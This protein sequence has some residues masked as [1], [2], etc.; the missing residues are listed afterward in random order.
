M[1]VSK[2]SHAR[3]VALIV[4]TCGI[5]ITLIACA[6]AT[7]VPP[8]SAPPPTAAPAT[9]APPPPATQAP[10]VNL[11]I[12]WW[13]EAD[14][15]GLEKWLE[16]TTAMYMKEN[17]NV[18][19]ETVL[20]S[21]ESLYPAFRAAAQAK[22]GPDVQYLWGAIYTLEDAW[23][24]N[25]APV[26]DYAQ[27]DVS[28]IFPSLREEATFDGKV[29]GLGWYMVPIT[30]A[31]RKDLFTQAGLDPN[32]PPATWDELL[33]A[34]EKL[35]AIGV[36]PLGYGFK[37]A[38]GHGNFAEQ[39][40]PQ[41]LDQPWEMLKFATGEE[42]FA[43]P[44]YVSWLTKVD[45]LNKKGC[46]N[47]DIMS[48][49]YQQGMDQLPAGKAAM[50]IAPVS[51]ISN[52]EKDLGA[53]KVGVMLAPVFGKGKIAGLMGNTAQV[54]AIPSFAPNKEASAAYL[55]YL[56]RPDRLK[57]MY[58]TSRALPADDR[59]DTSAVQSP[60]DKQVLAWA[61]D[62]AS[63]SYQDYIPSKID[64]ES[65]FVSIDK[66]ILGEKTPEQAAQEVEDFA[67]RWR[68]DNPEQLATLKKWLE[69]IQ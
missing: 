1:Q 26:S 11:T 68:T 31:Y 42:S 45:E 12:W 56:H 21:T 2:V 16:E 58:E 49:D 22:K 52:W 18:K 34:C 29:W 28:H 3:A 66:V 50:T 10:Q 48:L 55:S 67:V 24:G 7:A 32:K 64:R 54:M 15:P 20:Q 8:T 51:L 41:E 63:L 47:S 69:G 9:A 25:L 53:D 39:F 59:F 35:K 36:A 13:G 38:A 44:K 5:L 40:L 43:G 14:A 6:P 60:L 65:I 23:M 61:K 46:L 62:K 27:A 37:G 19:V 17:P 4:L 33:S 30:M 57:A